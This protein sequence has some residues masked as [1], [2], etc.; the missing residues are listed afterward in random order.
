MSVSSVVER[1][2]KLLALSKSDNAHE[3]AAAAAAA[4]RLIDQYRLSETD[5]EIQ[6]EVVEPMDE[7]EGYIYESGRVTPW[8]MTLMNILIRHYGLACWNHTSFATGRQVSRFK[9][10]G[11]KS[12]IAVAKYMFTWLTAECSRLSDIHAKGQGRI[13][14]ASWCAGFVDGVAAQLNASREEVKKVAS[15]AAI[16]KLDLRSQESKDFMWQLHPDLRKINR[17]SSAR[18]DYG[19]YVNGQQHGKRLHLGNSLG[20]GTKMLK[21]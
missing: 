3:A 2:Q 1:V 18:T 5:L 12:D 9:L 6:S 10:V 21:G 4:N 11:R 13:Y 19:A 16:I 8:K 15:Q 14:V 20:S 7:D 17:S